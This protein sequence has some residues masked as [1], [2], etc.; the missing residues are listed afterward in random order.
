MD[1]EGLRWEGYLR[2]DGA[3]GI[4]NKVLVVYTV[5]CAQFVAEEIARR[6]GDAET[7][8][9]GFAGCTDNAYAIRMLLAL[10]R[11]PNVGAVLAVGLGCEYT[12]PERLAEAARKAGKPA[13]WF[14][15]QDVGEL[16]LPLKRELTWQ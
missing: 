11:H 5:E 10:I 16:S 6:S 2:Q 15:I 9:I 4:R 3:L 14:F 7:E 1:L 8:V 12:Q 13:E